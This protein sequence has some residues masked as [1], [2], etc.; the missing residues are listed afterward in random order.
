MNASR[1]PLPGFSTDTAWQRPACGNLGLWYDKHY[2]NW[3]AWRSLVEPS[4]DKEPGAKLRWL[5][6]A[7]AAADTRSADRD[8]CERLSE[9][10]DRQGMFAAARGGCVFRARTVRKF[11]T[12]LGRAHPIDNG[13]EWHHTLGMPVLRGSGQKGI[14]RDW[15]SRWEDAPAGDIGRILG[16]QP[17]KA[18]RGAVEFLAA[19]PVRPPKLCIDGTTPHLTDYYLNGQPP[20]DWYDP[21]PLQWLAVEAGSEFQFAI[22]PLRAARPRSDVEQDVGKA[23]AWLVAALTE[24]GAGAATNADHGIFELVDEPSAGAST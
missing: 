3:P 12:G 20:A 18:T 22:V 19:L 14:V 13:F 21:V 24:L 9:H 16:G 17:P 4:N 10:A 23:R 8:L 1:A 2:R 5:E 6:A 15:A 7:V 11:V